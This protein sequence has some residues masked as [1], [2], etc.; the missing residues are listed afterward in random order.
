MPISEIK[1][2]GRSWPMV[3]AL[4]FAFGASLFTHSMDGAEPEGPTMSYRETRDYLVKHTNVIELTDQRGR[5]WQSARGG[6][7]A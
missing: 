7:V 6:R 2:D 4:V 5:G 3:A 1:R